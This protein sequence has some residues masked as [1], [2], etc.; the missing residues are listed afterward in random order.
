VTVS[1]RPYQQATV[2]AARTA[3]SAGKRA[4]I[5]V[6]PTGGG[7]TIVFSAIAHAALARG[8]RILILAHRRELIRQ[9][10]QK[11]T[12]AGVN[13]GIIAPGFT[14]SRDAVQVGSV[15]TVAR[16]LDELGEFD[17]III[18]EAHHSIAGQYRKIIEAQPQAR[19]LERKPS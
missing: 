1:L 10:S 9:A 4:P 8:K 19:L 18:D 2:D 7:K 11:L 15:Q 17:L 3:Y 12:D 14:P 5:V 6:L 16:R 13:H